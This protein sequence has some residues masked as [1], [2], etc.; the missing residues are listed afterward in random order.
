[1]LSSAAPNVA[2]AGR[3]RLRQPETMEVREAL[4]VEHNAS[5]AADLRMLLHR[6]EVDAAELL[7]LR[8][9]TDALGSELAEA[10]NMLVLSDDVREGLMQDA[11]AAHEQLE[12]ARQDLRE[13][14]SLERSGREQAQVQYERLNAQCE[15]CNRELQQKGKEVLIWEERYVRLEDAARAKDLDC[16][17]RVEAA[18]QGV[19]AAEEKS[20]RTE[21]DLAVLRGERRSHELLE[22]KLRGDIAGLEAQVQE[23]RAEQTRLRQ[24]AFRWQGSS[25]ERELQLQAGRRKEQFLGEQVA[26]LEGTL[27]ESTK[28]QEV[29]Y[30]ANAKIRALELELQGNRESA[31]SAK[32]QADRVKAEVIEEFQESLKRKQERLVALESLREKDLKDLGSKDEQLR[33]KDAEL[34]AKIAE[35]EKELHKQSEDLTIAKQELAR[36][37]Q[38]RDDV[39][40]RQSDQIR[41]AEDALEQKKQELE[42]K[43]KEVER[44]RA[45]AQTLEGTLADVNKGSSEVER[46]RAAVQTLEDTLADVNKG[47]SEVATLTVDETHDVHFLME[48]MEM[49]PAGW[50]IFQ[51]AEQRTY[52]LHQATRK[53]QWEPPKIMGTWSLRNSV[54]EITQDEAGLLF[55]LVMPQKGR[56]AVGVLHEVEDGWMEAQLTLDNNKKAGTIRV[57]ASAMPG[58]LT[59]NFWHA[60]KRAWTKSVTAHRVDSPAEAP[61]RRDSDHRGG[62]DRHGSEPQ[63]QVQRPVNPP[64]EPI[65]SLT[66][67]PGP[68][69]PLHERRNSRAP[70]PR[71]DDPASPNSRVVTALF[72]SAPAFP[73]TEALLAPPLPMP[74]GPPALGSRTPPSP[75]LGS[76]RG[77]RDSADKVAQ[78]TLRVYR[79]SEQRISRLHVRMLMTEAWIRWVSLFREAQLQA[80]IERAQADLQAQA[81]ELQALEADLQAHAAAD[82]IG[83][84]GIRTTYEPKDDDR[85]GSAESLG[86]ASAGGGPTPAVAAGGA[87][88]RRLVLE[89]RH[90]LMAS[91]LEL[92]SPD[93]ELA[94]A[95]LAEALGQLRHS[96]GRVLHALLFLYQKMRIFLPGEL[97]ET[98]RDP[99]SSMLPVPFYVLP[100]KGP[101]QLTEELVGRA[102]S[103]GPWPPLPPEASPR[104][105]GT[106]PRRLTAWMA[107]RVEELEKALPLHDAG[108][109]EVPHFLARLLWV[110]GHAVRAL[111]ACG[112]PEL[113]MEEATLHDRFDVLLADAL[114]VYMSAWRTAADAAPTERRQPSPGPRLRGAFAPAVHAG[115]VRG[116]RCGAEDLHSREIQRLRLGNSWRP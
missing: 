5:L 30:A 21:Q 8:A 39:A 43:E 11:Q 59:L 89:C 33:K 58:E 108:S 29:L 2:G 64:E 60:G 24:E 42:Q 52:Y 79:W 116:R 94:E 57:K 76:R 7:A 85:M 112:L 49:V 115:A 6:S 100:Y 16:E 12:R 63:Q 71:L 102:A 99:A 32:M 105:R 23:Q 48:T 13:L 114:T 51:D 9:K 75:A 95:R 101:Q 70:T 113:S 82:G 72:G 96:F 66:L 47:S 98:M 86:R 78:L 111:G 67:E 93:P 97:A 69:R 17:R 1:M 36:E 14:H 46:L 62:R 103:P 88:L 18:Q 34:L 87:A 25:E 38:R 40:G 31:A 15:A 44:L 77:S 104:Q 54:C 56:H 50:R 65:Q 81:A 106:C 10:R 20:Q 107:Q 3:L 68:S 55:S 35:C 53:L 109:S 45:A 80:Y 73:S 110:R 27:A 19:K 91:F 61:E 26:R 41:A 90:R 4:L 84:G 83:F 74:P 22:A 28:Q 37:V 92:V